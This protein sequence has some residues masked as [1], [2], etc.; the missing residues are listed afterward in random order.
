MNAGVLLDGYLT[1]RP[2]FYC[3]FLVNQALGALFLLDGYLTGYR[4]ARGEGD[5]CAA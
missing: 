5:F 2:A 4:T 1:G 3:V